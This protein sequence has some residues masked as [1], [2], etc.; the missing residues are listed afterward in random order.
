MMEW[1]LHQLQ[2]LWYHYFEKVRLKIAVG[3]FP[4]GTRFAKA[5]FDSRLMLFEFAENDSSVT[6]EA[7]VHYF[8]L[9][10]IVLGPERPH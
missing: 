5:G 2:E 9:E 8:P 10:E 1:E 3:Q 7:K 4:A 6:K